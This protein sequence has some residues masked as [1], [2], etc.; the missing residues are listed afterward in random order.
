[1]KK[2]ISIVT[3]ALLTGMTASASLVV[4]F[5]AP[6]TSNTEALNRS[7]DVDGAGQDAYYFNDTTYLHDAGANGQNAQIYGGITWNWQTTGNTDP[8]YRFNANNGIYNQGPSITGAVG[9]PSTNTVQSMYVWKAADFL[10]ADTDFSGAGSNLDYVRKSNNTSTYEFRFVVQEAGTYYASDDYGNI[11]DHN[12]DVTTATWYEI[13]VGTAANSG[14]YSFAGTS[15]ALTL[16]D[17]Q[18]V[19][20]Y[21]AGENVDT[22]VRIGMSDFNATVIPEP[23]TLGLVAAFGGGLLFVRRFRKI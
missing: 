22:F 16:T 1:M 8:A 15:T 9:S 13:T 2:T 7:K 23:A 5:Q 6:Y 18:S 11:N 12:L 10:V 17:L 19:G 21:A 20:F 14:A 3:L 4:D